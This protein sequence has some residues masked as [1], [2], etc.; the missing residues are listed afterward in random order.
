MEKPGAERSQAGETLLY[1]LERD[2]WSEALAGSL[3]LPQHLLPPTVDAGTRIGSLSEVAASDL[4]LASGIPIAAGGGDT[5]CGLLGAGVLEPRT[6][7]S[8]PGPPFPSRW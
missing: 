3:G 1:D 4:G 8:S 6:W 7:G 2:D 5:Q